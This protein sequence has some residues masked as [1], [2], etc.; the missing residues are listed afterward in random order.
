MLLIHGVS[1]T[2]E[3]QWPQ[4]PTYQ[5]AIPLEIADPS[6]TTRGVEKMFVTLRRCKLQDE[7]DEVGLRQKA[8]R[9]APRV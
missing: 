7:P 9:K 1:S 3:L 2:E 8:S 4:W 6:K 5:V